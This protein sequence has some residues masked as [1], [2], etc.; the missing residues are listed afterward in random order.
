MLRGRLPVAIT[1]AWGGVQCLAETAGPCRPAWRR[2]RSQCRC[3][4]CRRCWSPNSAL[5]RAFQLHLGQLGGVAHQG[6]Q[7]QAGG[8]QNRAPHNA[9]GA[10]HRQQGWRRCPGSSQ[11]GAACPAAAPPPCAQRAAPRPAGLGL[12]IRMRTPLFRP[13]PTVISGA[14]LI[15]AMASRTREVRAGTTLDRMALSIS[16]G[17]RPY[18]SSIVDQLVGQLV[19]AQ[20]TVRVQLGGKGSAFPSGVY[21]PQ[22][23]FEFPI[24]MASSMACPSPF[25]CCFHYKRNPRDCKGQRR[26]LFGPALPIYMERERNTGG[27]DGG[28][29][30]R[31]G[32]AG[33]GGVPILLPGFP[34]GFHISWR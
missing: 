25:A 24:L 2:S 3:A 31:A 23:M 7:R 27:K 4:G 19:R 9:A 15:L 32:E 12:S 10:V 11:S 34:P 5:G 30:A 16:S 21:P 17:D 13:G 14:R 33:T 18:R 1:G 28:G 29:M 8:G 6:R 26:G 20:G 22:V